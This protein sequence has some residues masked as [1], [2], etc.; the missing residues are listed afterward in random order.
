[1]DIHKNNKVDTMCIEICSLTKPF[2]LPCVVLSMQN[3]VI[4]NKIKFIPITMDIIC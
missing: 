1:M 2:I 4:L 3:K